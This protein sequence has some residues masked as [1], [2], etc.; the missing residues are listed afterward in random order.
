MR[1]SQIIRVAPTLIKL[2]MPFFLK[3]PVG[4]GKSDSMQ[5]VC[6]AMGIELRDVRLSQMDPTDI[7]GFPCPEPAKNLMRWLPAD[8]L[9]TKGKGLLFLD[10]LTSAPQAVQAAAY[11]L[12][13]GFK[14]G[15]YTLPPGWSVAGAGNR[16]IDRAI[17]NRMPSALA[18]RFLHIDYD[19]NLEDFVDYAIGQ[20]IEST[21][22]AFVRFR[23]NL[24]HNFDAS[25]NPSAF[26]TPRSWFMADRIMKARLADEDEYALIK[27]C[28]GE[29][30][31][32]QHR[33]F[34]KVAKDL[35]TTD[36]IKVAPDTTKVPTE[37]STLHA[38]T[39]GLSMA[40]ADNTAFGRFMVYVLRMPVEF[41]V[42][43]VRDC[44]KRIKTLGT[45]PTFTKWSIKH[46][47]VIA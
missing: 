30:A 20:G 47:N 16:E 1:P 14:V 5:Q 29:D 21:T 41:Q 37:P 15:N 13:L 12:A 24:L 26:P 39:T 17:V 4:V 19:V 34:V 32:S 36:E 8:F 18:N 9:P 43:Y 6:D 42:V 22:I 31:A 45:D 28:V 25:Q 11:Q 23:E 7:K 40:T 3:G 27:G 46:H 10:E 44:L 38:L 33:A 2:R 35:P